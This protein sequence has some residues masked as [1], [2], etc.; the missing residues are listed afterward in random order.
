MLQG[1]KAVR[2]LQHCGDTPS[3]QMTLCSGHFSCSKCF[4][5][6]LLFEPRNPKVFYQDLWMCQTKGSSPGVL[7]RALE[8]S[9]CIGNDSICLHEIRCYY[10]SWLNSLPVNKAM[11]MAFNVQLFAGR[12]SGCPAKSILRH[13]CSTLDILPWTGFLSGCLQAWVH[14]PRVWKSRPWLIRNSVFNMCLLSLAHMLTGE[15][16]S[17]FTY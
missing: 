3:I 4:C 6:Q 1:S 9:S 7:D 11:M 8:K 2:S 13:C 12:N 16:H 14:R 10:W 15:Y 17:H 5:L